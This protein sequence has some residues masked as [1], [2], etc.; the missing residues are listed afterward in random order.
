MLR[1]LGSI[2]CHHKTTYTDKAAVAGK[3]YLYR[4]LPYGRV[5]GVA[6]FGPYSS[7]VEG[8]MLKETKI[9]DVKSYVVKY[10]SHGIK[11]QE[12]KAI[13][14]IVITTRQRNGKL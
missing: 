8:M 14:F 5:N 12:H 10:S 2:W 9:K 1:K 6:F 13:M 3:R 7:S 4:V 11:Y